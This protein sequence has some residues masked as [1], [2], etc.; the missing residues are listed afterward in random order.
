MTDF[1]CDRCPELVAS[2]TQIVR[3]RGNPHAD[4][5]CVGEAP[6][7]TEDQRGKAFCG[8]AGQVLA[9]LL[10]QAGIDLSRVYLANS[11]ACR[12][13]GNRTP[14]IDEVRNCREYLLEEIATVQPKVIVC[15]GVSALKS[16]WG[17]VPIGDVL[18]QSLT[19]ADSGIPLIPTYHPA[20]VMRS[21]KA[22]PVVL[23]HMQKALRIANEGLGQQELG[24]YL[25]CTW[26]DAVRAA[27]DYLLSESSQIIAFDCVTPDT[28]I[29]TA[30]L[31][32]KPAGQLVAGDELF[33]FDEDI[34][35]ES[36]CRRYR[37]AKVVTNEIRFS[38]L[39]ELELSDGTRLRCT[40]NHRWLVR[41][42]E[43]DGERLGKFHWVTTEE[44]QQKL[45][46]HYG[47]RGGRKVKYAIPRLFKPWERDTT[48]D[49]GWI[50]GMFDADGCLSGRGGACHRSSP[51]LTQKGGPEMTRAV[52]LLTERGF[53]CGE[54]YYPSSLSQNPCGRLWIKGGFSEELRFL[55]E[56]SPPRLL[57]RWREQND[58][59]G[60]MVQS[61]NYVEVK[62]VHPI[63]Q[64][65][66][67]ALGTTTKT[68]IAAGFPA[69]NT[70][71]T[72]LNWM[73]D[74]LMCISLSPEPGL[75]F[76]IPILRQN[77]EQVWT[78]EEWPEVRALIGE[79]LSSSKCKAGQNASFDLRFLERERDWPCV[80][81][82]T[83]FGWRVNNLK[84]DTLILSRAIC[85]EVPHNL[86]AL[87][88]F[89]TDTPYYSG[90]V[91]AAS[92]RKRHMEAVPDEVLWKY[93]GADADM[94]MRLLPVL[95]EQIRE[96]G[97]EWLFE[98]IV[99]PT[100][101]SC[102]EMEKR[103]LLVD[104]PLF[105]QMSDHYAQ[106]LAETE[107]ELFELV[108]GKVNYEDYR[109]VQTLLFDKC[110]IP[111]PNER[112]DGVAGCKACKES[113]G[114]PCIKHV[115][116]DRQTLEALMLTDPHPVLPVLLRAKKLVKFYGTYLAGGQGGYGRFIRPDGRIHA[117]FKVGFAD[118]GRHSCEDPNLQNPPRDPPLPEYKDALR[119]IF[120][121]PQGH[122]MMTADWAQVE[123]W[124]LAYQT[125]DEKLLNLLRTGVDVHTYV[126]RELGR[127]G[128]SKFFPDA[129][130]ELDDYEWQK[131]HTSDIRRRA[132]TF[133]FGISYGLTADGAADRLGCSV[134]E[135]EL[136]IEAY[137]T[138]VFPSLE[139]YFAWVETEI[140]TKGYLV[141]M[142]G[143]R[144]SFPQVPVLKL[145]NYQND[146]EAL[147]RVAVNFPI[148][149]AAHDLHQAAH[150]QT[151]ACPAIIAR[152]RPVLEVHDSLSFEAVDKG[153]DYLVQTAWLIKELWE[154]TAQNLILPSGKRLGWECPVE[155]A[156]GP[157]L[158]ETHW[159]LTPRGDLLDVRGLADET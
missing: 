8:K 156:W 129:D 155:I 39:Y 135:G 23:A 69:H 52:S 111:I 13:P 119:Q 101:R 99:T 145:L 35:A 68:Y 21:W 103:G 71:T 91:A 158:G 27:R 131:L 56:I 116:T 33:G 78:Q 12:P 150:N 147:L 30:D 127:L 34:P 1:T 105:D 108:G 20:Y 152:A 114:H 82:K 7:Q 89:F 14:K 63:G 11:C 5:M 93:A 102:W 49:A 146:I 61:R 123:V 92:K 97:T 159:K 151:E 77:L 40:G 133:T 37:V 15:L 83:A 154:K 95:L 67:A 90:E 144:R 73:T 25:P 3:G 94:V 138:K 50:A 16:L 76:I 157:S 2:R 118:T 29:L 19:Q 120:V 26:V 72:G 115:K 70:E 132:K 65:P 87:L 106:A 143:R 149:S 24:E 100:I 153:Q 54:G 79:I 48:R 44:M 6:G 88:A 22:A 64:G 4:I 104:Q 36:G 122:A 62:A 130:P 10:E 141:N 28:P 136:L 85:Q 117:T 125:Q 31:E 59:S 109:S 32:W 110:K 107:K 74:E 42:G 137:K 124:M 47:R 121:A 18:G 51:N 86:D 75:A 96:Q 58:F 134:D 60:H 142:F 55:G 57:R 84:W 80:E 53:S 43:T 46:Q 41:G 140:L 81:A 128:I 148:Q 9:C 98:K 66:I 17:T 113:K 38:D 45:Q 126:G 139:E 112:T